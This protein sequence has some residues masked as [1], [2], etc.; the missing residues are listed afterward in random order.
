MLTSRI[1]ERLSALGISQAEAARRAG[2]AP[3]WIS[4]LTKGRKKGAQRRSLERMAAALITTPDY[5][6][7]KTNNPGPSPDGDPDVVEQALPRILS[8]PPLEVKGL[9]WLNTWSNMPPSTKRMFRGDPRLIRPIMSDKTALDPGL[10]QH[11]FRTYGRSAEPRIPLLSQ[12]ATDFP[13]A[14]AWSERFPPPTP[15]LPVLDRAVGCYALVMPDDSM[16]PAIEPQWLIYVRPSPVYYTDLVVVR[17]AAKTQKGAI[18]L[19]RRLLGDTADGIALALAKPERT[20]TVALRDILSIHPVFALGRDPAMYTSK[21]GYP[22]Y[23]R[24]AGPDDE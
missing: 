18:F 10:Q 12:P 6:S 4:D 20:E 16:Y 8:A 17:L 13:G 1:R 21:P 15:S 19:I 7:G 9:S 2:L 3:G 23:I 14:I 24:P 11:W 5:L 22:L